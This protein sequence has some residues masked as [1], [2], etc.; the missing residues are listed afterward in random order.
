[1][2]PIVLTLTTARSGARMLY[3]HFSLVPDMSADHEST[4]GFP[5]VRRENITNPS[6][7]RE[8]VHRFVFEYI[9]KKPGKYYSN[10]D[11]SVSCGFVE[12][13]L[14]LGVRPMF[15]IL[16]R[17]PRLVATSMFRLD[18]IPERHHFHRKWYSSPRESSALPIFGW[19]KM[20][21]YQL[22]YWYACDC[23]LRIQKAKK[24]VTDA[25]CLT[26]ETT[27][28]L[29]SDTSHFNIMLDHFSFPNVDKLPEKVF[30]TLNSS[31]FKPE[32]PKE[33]LR[34]LE[35]EVLDSIPPDAANNLRSRGWGS[36]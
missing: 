30:N 26:W 8:F 35:N 10:T 36:I 13:F 21:A 31:K 11:Q 6:I 17:N 25:G 9:E 12:H 16:R 22:C 27:P 4:P 34:E 18:W 15:V 7:G 2:K 1:M 28:E 5:S 33:F 29:V 3:R 14:D 19:E 23:E 32:P 24:L 20:H